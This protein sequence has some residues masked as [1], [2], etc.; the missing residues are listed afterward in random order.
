MKIRGSGVLLHITS[1][2]SPYGIGDLGPSAYRFLDFLHES[3]QRYWQ[4]LPLNPTDSVHSDSPYSSIS[5]FA[6]NPL[7]ISPEFLVRNGLLLSS[8]LEPV[9]DLPGGRIDYPQVHRA[10]KK[11]LASAYERFRARGNREDFEKF[12]REE[13]FWLEDFALFRALK[14]IQDSQTWGD[15]PP[16]LRDRNLQA[17]A[18]ARRDFSAAI[19]KE[20]FFQ[21]L[22]SNQ[23]KDLRHHAAA[24]GIQIIGDIPIYVDYD[25][26]DVWAHPERFKLNEQKKPFVVSGVPPDC[27]SKTGQRWGNPLYDWEVM[28]QT[29]YPW[30]V[31]RIAH[32]LKL[33]D[34]I[35]IDHF[36]G[37]VAFWEIPVEEATAVNGKWVP[38]PA[39]DFFNHLLRI[40]PRL[41]LIAEDLGLITPDVHEVMDHFGFPG[42][43]VLLFAFG[44]DLPT[45]PYIPHNL[46][47]HCV[48]FTGT[49][50]NNTVR[51]WF[52]EE[53]TPE[54]RGR[55]FRYL[56]REIPPE[57]VPLAL[58]RLLMR[59]AADTVITPMQ[60]LL[61][62]G[63]EGRMN[64]PGTREGNWGWRLSPQLL[65]S[66]RAAALREMTEIYGRT[67]KEKEE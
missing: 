57:E 11:F 52:E 18:K 4:I 44:P 26:A 33:V 29:G 58:V 37:F 31:Q 9:S 66:D 20:K 15:W 51:G 25:S 17:L 16:A 48:A 12:C 67:G 10:K 24:R 62:L 60:D 6:G 40:F 49:H 36:R 19:E 23:W 30:W 45:N 54:E 42:M 14:E 7:L 43:K 22:F 53:A 21:F 55:L 34:W 32:N 56:G 63:A 1:L 47:R 65:S 59:S 3:K 64:F 35:R 46:P 8:E 61:G 50:D 27:F 38:A 28:R 39:M 5:A 41:P 2:P 13:A